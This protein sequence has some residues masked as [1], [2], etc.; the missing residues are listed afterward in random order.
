MANLDGF[1]PQYFLFQL[2]LFSSF[3]FP[4]IPTDLFA[5]ATWCRNPSQNFS[6]CDPGD[7]R[8]YSFIYPQKEV[9]QNCLVSL[10]LMYPFTSVSV[11][12]SHFILL[13]FHQCVCRSLSNTEDKCKDTY[14]SNSSRLLRPYDN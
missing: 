2:L 12:L 9:A 6:Q 11:D 4:V 13:P 7:L 5:V 1:S 8:T 14:L 10:S 3:S